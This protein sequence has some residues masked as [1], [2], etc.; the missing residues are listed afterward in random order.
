MDAKV[1]VSAYEERPP[2]RRR[3]RPISRV[4]PAAAAAPR[5]AG[6]GYSRRAL[7]LAYAQ[8]LRR[9]RRLGQQQRGPRLLEWGE[10][11][12]A[13]RVAGGDVAVTRNGMGSWCSRLRSCARLWIR[14][15]FR[16]TRRIRENASCKK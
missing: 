3:R 15:F 14:T 10:W 16:R 2:R 12:A 7:L 1:I 11:K 9:R 4:A 5:Q 6:G 13:G 8:Q